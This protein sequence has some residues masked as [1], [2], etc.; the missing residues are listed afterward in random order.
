MTPETWTSALEQHWLQQLRRGEEILMLELSTLLGIGEAGGVVFESVQVAKEDFLTA[1]YEYFERRRSSHPWD[2]EPLSMSEPPR[3]LLLIAIQV[4]AAS[5][6]ADDPGG[7]Y[8]EKAYYTQL[9]SLL[10]R[11]G[12]SNNFSQE[13]GEDHQ[14]LWRKRLLQW[15]EKHNVTVTIPPRLLGFGQARLPAKVTSR[16][17]TP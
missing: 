13:L 12:L 15:C 3:F 6:M 1:F 9:E 16:L 17:S 11:G 7:Q 10:G 8:T 2:P 4:L 5:C 14:C